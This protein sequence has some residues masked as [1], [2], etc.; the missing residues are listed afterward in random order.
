M[1][2]LEKDRARRYETANGLAADLR[3]YLDD[4]PVLACPPSTAYRFRKFAR[5][6]KATIAS[7]VVIGAAL[8]LG[9]IGTTWQAIRATQAERQAQTNLTQAN[10]QRD[11]A[12]QQRDRAELAA[13]E[14]EKARHQESVQRKL[15]SQQQVRAEENL[16]RAHQAVRDYLTIV[17]D[18]EELA[19]PALQ[20]L[21]SKL[22]QSALGYYEQF[23]T[24]K[25]DDP[26]LKLEMAVTYLRVGQVYYNIDRLDDAIAALASGLDILDQLRRDHPDVAHCPTSVSGFWRGVQSVRRDAKAP[27]DS[28]VA[29]ATLRRAINLW[30]EFVDECPEEAGF[31][32]DLAIF[33][34]HNVDL[35]SSYAW[36]GTTQ[37]SLHQGAVK[38]VKQDAE[39]ALELLNQLVI[40]HPESQHYRADLALVGEY[41]AR[42]ARESKDWERAATLSERSLTLW[43]S[44]N[45]EFPQQ[46]RYRLSFARSLLLTAD[47]H[48]YAG[49]VAEAEAKYRHSIKLVQGLT[50][51][52]PN[53]Q[54]YAEALSDSLCSFAMLLHQQGKKEEAAKQLQAANEIWDFQIAKSSN[55][56][57]M[58]VSFEHLGNALSTT[59]HKAEAVHVYQKY[60]EGLAHAIEAQPTVPE[61]QWRRSIALRE[62]GFILSQL[63][64]QREAIE[65]FEEAHV[66]VAAL[67]AA[68]PDE[69]KYKQEMKDHSAML[70]RRVGNVHAAKNDF[71]L[72]I[73]DFNEAIRI[74]PEYWPAYINRG[75][76]YWYTQQ[77]ELA[78][79]DANH[80]LEKRPWDANYLLGHIHLAQGDHETAISDFQ[81]AIESKPGSN[82]GYNMKGWAQLRGGRIKDAS[83]TINRAVEL[84]IG[85]DDRL[86]AFWCFFSA[87]VCIWRKVI[88][89]RPWLTFVRLWRPLTK[90]WAS[91]LRCKSRKH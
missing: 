83:A 29:M 27:V 25:T 19:I 22:L 9:M 86:G 80:I 76:A 30:E 41:V 33:R 2:A 67:N 47:R 69:Q 70:R 11:I 91:I 14:A 18:S 17:S 45:E 75:W 7:A 55:L 15:A 31:R 26:H 82:W 42:L 57:A 59:G 50:S 35:I 72:A 39:R 85:E 5:R 6:N 65:S 8:L 10:E 44:L 1:K 74:N 60:V 3:R 36:F 88:E 58:S 51:E 49:H 64:R 52:F 4:E 24:Q 63:N 53:V 32:A 13:Q 34:M 78:L 21:R 40:E 23:L 48:R 66:T 20:T 12:S 79:K 81:R 46:V 77:F 37:G 62:L 71:D 16:E 43:T 73:S 84:A 56:A 87:P 68:Y 38:T 61:H 90:A 28:Q 54:S 89:M